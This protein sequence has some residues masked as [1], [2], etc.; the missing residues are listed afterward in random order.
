MDLRDWQETFRADRILLIGLPR[1]ARDVRKSLLVLIM[2]RDR[3]L[4]CLA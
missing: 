2:R 4:F 3:L 1:F